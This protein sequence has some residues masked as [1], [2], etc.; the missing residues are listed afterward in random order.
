MLM[1]CALIVAS[2]MVQTPDADF[3]DVLDSYTFSGTPLRWAPQLTVA[4]V[5]SFKTPSGTV[6]SDVWLG[7]VSLGDNDIALFR[8]ISVERLKSQE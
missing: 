4:E 7:A 1:Q 6:V 3:L 8:L 5:G 2:F